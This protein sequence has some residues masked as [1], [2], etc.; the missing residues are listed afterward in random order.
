H[1][2]S[3][4]TQRR[5]ELCVELR[6]RMGPQRDRPHRALTGLDQE[7]VVD[8]VEIELERPRAVRDRGRRQPARGHVE[9][10]VPRVV[11]PGTPGQADLPDDLR[12]PVQRGVRVLPVLQG[13]AWPWVG[14]GTRLHRRPPSGCAY[15]TR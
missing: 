4:L 2:Q 13:Q 11:D 14:A 7:P 15:H 6:Y 12:P 5:E 9:G 3:E 10:D 8:E 1:L